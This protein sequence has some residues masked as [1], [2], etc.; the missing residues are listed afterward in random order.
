[1]AGIELLEEQPV[2]TPGEA[3][4]TH[5]R[6]RRT[7]GQGTGPPGFSARPLR[8]APL[9][10]METTAHSTPSTGGRRVLPFEGAVNAP[11][12]GKARGDTSIPDALSVPLAG[13]GNPG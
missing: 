5:V 6:I 12:S 10:V 2:L 11:K 13:P 1:M 9:G 8:V 4:R 7:T 3:H